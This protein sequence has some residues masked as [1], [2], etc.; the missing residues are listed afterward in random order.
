MWDAR[1]RQTRNA[2][3]M[4]FTARSS[5]SLYVFMDKWSRYLVIWWA[6]PNEADPTVRLVRRSSLAVG[7]TMGLGVCEKNGRV[8]PIYGIVFGASAHVRRNA[9][10]CERLLWLLRRGRVWCAVKWSIVW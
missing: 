2:K 5:T 9:N 7:T 1:Q 4:P 8:S 10:G 6:M 3:I